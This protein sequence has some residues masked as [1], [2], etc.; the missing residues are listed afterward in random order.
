[1]QKTKLIMA[2]RS[3]QGAF[4]QLLFSVRHCYDRITTIKK[5]LNSNIIKVKFKVDE[6]TKRSRL[7][8]LDQR[9]EGTISQA[10]SI[11]TAAI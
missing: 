11:L 1:M 2:D 4:D 9:G 10:I 5:G 3:G 6:L 8:L 7:I